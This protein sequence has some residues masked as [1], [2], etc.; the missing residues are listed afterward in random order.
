MK[1][2]RKFVRDIDGITN[3]ETIVAVS[4]VVIAFSVV[5]ASFTAPINKEP[6]SKKV[7]LNDKALEVLNLLV[8]STGETIYKQTEWQDDV[9]KVKTIGLIP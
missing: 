4:V 5:F 2:I 1:K 7:D 6:L 8:S 3:I 9:A